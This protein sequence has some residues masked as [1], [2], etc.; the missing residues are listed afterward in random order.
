MLLSIK[1]AKGR[2]S[3]T[4]TNSETRRLQLENH[5]SQQQA[6]SDVTHALENLQ[7][8]TSY[9]SEVIS[10]YYTNRDDYLEDVFREIR[11]VSS[12]WAN[13]LMRSQLERKLREAVQNT[14]DSLPEEQDL[15]GSEAVLEGNEKSRIPIGAPSYSIASRPWKRECVARASSTLSTM[16]GQIHCSSQAYRILRQGYGSSVDKANSHQ[17]TDYIV[18][19]SFWLVPSAWLVKFG[20]AYT[21]HV[22]VARSSHAGWNHVLKTFNVCFCSSFR[23]VQLPFREAR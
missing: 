9:Q 2:Y 7:A 8:Q 20:V 22:Q 12:S 23:I 17:R 14:V 11:R 19:S 18:E 4:T 1:R 6:L 16:F 15:A 10:A 13:P 21:V 3:K 5:N